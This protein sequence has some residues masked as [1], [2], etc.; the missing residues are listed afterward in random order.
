MIVSHAIKPFRHYGLV[1][2]EALWIDGVPYFT[3]KAIATF[4]ELK[5]GFRSVDRIVNRN[6]D[7]KEYSR[8][9]TVLSEEVIPDQDENKCKVVNLT[10]TCPFK[11]PEILD[12]IKR[13]GGPGY[14]TCLECLEKTKP[15]TRIRKINITVFHPIG[16]NLILMN[17][18][19][20]KAKEFKLC[21]AKL[22]FTLIETGLVDPKP[23]QLSDNK[24]LE[25][26]L[27]SDHGLRKYYIEEYQKRIGCCRATAF[28][29][30]K[31]IKRGENPTD[32]KKRTQLN[33]TIISGDIEFKIREIFLKNPGISIRKMHEMIG[34][35]KSPSLTTVKRFVNG[36]KKE[37]KREEKSDMVGRVGLVGQ[38]GQ[39][40]E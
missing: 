28:N 4:L 15:K 10:Q 29:H 36:L 39:I 14:Y 37:F 31:M 32:K 35:P 40:G 34:S 22:L 18:D 9:I 6:P 26:A 17:S 5:D 21:V 2:D 3:S 25:M 1:L 23:E 24:M 30:L 12:I 38:A 33:Q 11:D 20:P 8:T 16:L 13:K 19:T 27:V 7:I